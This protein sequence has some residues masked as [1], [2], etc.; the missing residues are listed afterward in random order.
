MNIRKFFHYTKAYIA[1]FLSVLIIIAWVLA[2][3][4]HPVSNDA[5]PVCVVIPNGSPAKE[6]A[7]ILKKEGVIRS[8]F[9]FTLTCRFGGMSSTLKPGVYELN[10][11]MSLQ[12]IIE[13]LVAAKTVESWVTVPEGYTAKDIG[14]LLD[15]KKLVNSSVFVET[16]INRGYEF[17]AYKF[18]DDENLEG[19]LFPDTYLIGKDADSQQIIRTMLSTFDKK[20]LTPN[21]VELRNTINKRFGMDNSNFNEGLRKIITIASIVEREAKTPDDRFLIAAVIWNRLE[22]NMRLEIDATVS[23]RPGESKSNK[24]K[25][26]YSD[27]QVDSAYNTYK[28]NGIPPAP[29][30]NP[31]LASVQAVLNPAQVDYFYYVA[32]PDG[33]HVFSRTYKEHLKAKNAKKN[34]KL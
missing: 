23:Y 28:H 27:L 18:I 5:S 3:G 22:K 2:W 7:L 13:K 8:S 10:R 9:V 32:K 33:S 15:S 6:I 17:P 19:Y 1:V 4:S 16:A 20:V 31:G 29:I 12:Q 25:V 14:D 24:S 26:Y 34:G 21:R 30:C 11:A